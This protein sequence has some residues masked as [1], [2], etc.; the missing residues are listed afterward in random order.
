MIKPVFLPIHIAAGIAA[1]RGSPVLFVAD[2]APFAVTIFWLVRLRSPKMIAHLN[3]RLASLQPT[4]ATV[5]C[6]MEI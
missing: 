6:N 2:F 1:V 4:V 3:F 5:R